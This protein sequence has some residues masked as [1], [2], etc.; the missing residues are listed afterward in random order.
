MYNK[1]SLIYKKVLE[2]YFANK[3]SIRK[4]AEKFKIHYQTVYKWIKK[5]KLFGEKAFFMHKKHPNRIP[6]KIEHLVAEC[7]ERFPYLTVK[8]AQKLLKKNGINISYHGI[9][10]VW[11]RYGYCG[12]TNSMLS[13]DFTEYVSFTSESRRKL[14]EA[15]R[16]Y[17]SGKIL[18][19]TRLLNQI[20]CLPKNELILKLP[21]ELLNTKRKIERLFMEFGRIPLAEYIKKTKNIYQK[22]IKNKWNYSAL[23]IGMALIA[24]LSWKS[25]PKDYEKWLKKIESLIPHNKTKSRD[26]FP[27]YFSLLITRSLALVKSLKI[28]E[29]MKIAGFCYNKLMYRKKKQYDFMYDLAILFSHLEDYNK[30]EILLRQAIEGISEQRKTRAKAILAKDV[31]LNRCDK[32]SAMK[33]LNEG[34]I[35]DWANDA[36]ILRMQSHLCLIE[37]D[38]SESLNFALKALNVSKQ[39]GL[40]Q[41]IAGSYIAVA[42]AHMCLNETKKSKSLLNELKKFLKNK[43]M[44]RE[45]L[46]VNSLLLKIP[47]N[48]DM[49]LLSTIK[50]TW[51]LKHRGY[52]VAYEFAHKKGI[53]FYFYRYVIFN[54]Q[55]VQKRI[56]NK[57]PVFLPK[58]ILK[59]PIFD[60]GALLLRINFLGEVVIYRNQKYVKDKLT[61]KNNAILCYIASKSPEPQKEFNIS[62]IIFNFWQ[63]NPDSARLFSHSLM[64]IKETLKIP[65]HY[66]EIKRSY[67]DSFLVNYNLYFTT[68]YDTFQQTLARAKALQ[69]AGEWEFAKKEYLQAF[70]LFRGEP[71][72]KNFDDWSVNMRFRILSE[73]ETE[74]INFAKACL[75]HNNK[76]VA[77]KTLEKVLKI[78]PDSEEVH[79]TIANL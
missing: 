68:D 19:S 48:K 31:Y 69:R 11:H 23:R 29:A 13:N 2:D 58:T 27:F 76:R 6:A 34:T 22:C 21:Y 8:E 57:K 55:I 16:L 18:E 32:D 30:E 15:E 54:P 53:M 37:G 5:Y 51:L 73:L 3:S 38:I 46:Y 10:N 60:P 66:L 17:E 24:A 61:P 7:K 26:L 40:L 63:N 64:R 39:V 25:T 43:K 4:T 33:F 41:A 78:I 50:L 56:A 42:T 71:F 35:Y 74:A 12:F 36:Q 28:K 9:W 65:G 52:K 44:Y 20:P 72:K 70:K 79:K 45:L 1:Y 67:G 59:L 14:Q 47:A 77:M 75:E 49:L 62:E